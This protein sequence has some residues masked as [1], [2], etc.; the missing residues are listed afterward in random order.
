MKASSLSFFLSLAVG[1]HACS[2]LGKKRVNT[3]LPNSLTFYDSTGEI[4]ES[5][6]CSDRQWEKSQESV[7]AKTM[8]PRIDRTIL[9]VGK[10]RRMILYVC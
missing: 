6:L 4:I 9:Y 8:M 7:K 1:A 3:A 10:V 2:T 5:K